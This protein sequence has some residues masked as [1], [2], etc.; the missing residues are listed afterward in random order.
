MTKTAT[1]AIIIIYSH[2]F[3][4][5]TLAEV[6]WLGWSVEGEGNCAGEWFWFLLVSG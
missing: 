1:P 5:A 2:N 3:P 4:E 6:G